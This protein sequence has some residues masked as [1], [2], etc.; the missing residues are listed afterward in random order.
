MNFFNPFPRT[1][2]LIW[3]ERVGGEREKDTQTSN[4]ES[5]TDQLLPIGAPNGNQT[6]NLDI[7]PDREL[8]SQPFGVYIMMFQPAEPTVQGNECY[9]LWKWSISKTLKCWRG[10]ERDPSC[11]GNLVI[12]LVAQSWSLF[13]GHNT[14]PQVLSVLTAE[15]S[16]LSDFLKNYSLL[17]GAGPP[18]S[19]SYLEKTIANEWL[20]WVRKSHPLALSQDMG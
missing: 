18:E 2:L 4:C 5:N 13:P 14:Y 11:K 9:S 8:N 15:T 7:R 10:F 20:I 19:I 12:L 3:R 6:Q 17:T 16:Q 1:C